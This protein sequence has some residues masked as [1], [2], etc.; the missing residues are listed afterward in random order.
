MMFCSNTKG[1]KSM[2]LNML[3]WQVI[4]CMSVKL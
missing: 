2:K 3:F 1:Q 4:L